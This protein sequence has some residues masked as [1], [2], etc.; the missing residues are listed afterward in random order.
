MTANK[1]RLPT[2]FDVEDD[3]E[4]NELLKRIGH[5][6]NPVIILDIDYFDAEDFNCLPN[7]KEV[8]KELL[9]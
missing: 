7:N 5:S 1:L 8:T 2:L 9:G 3:F 6:L 4:W